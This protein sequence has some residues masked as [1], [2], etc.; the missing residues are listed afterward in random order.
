MLRQISIKHRLMA[1]AVAIVI[2]LLI[3]FAAWWSAFNDLKING[4]AYARIVQTKDL[5]SGPIKSLA[6]F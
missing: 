5:G 4:A 1:V 2:T 3:V 6:S